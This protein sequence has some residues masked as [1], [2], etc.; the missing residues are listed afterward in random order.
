MGAETIALPDAVRQPSPI[1]AETELQ[2]LF[3]PTHLATLATTPLRREHARLWR[4]DAIHRA[5]NLAQMTTS[6][7]DVAGHPSRRWLPPNVNLTQPD[8]ACDLAFLRGSGQDADPEYMLSNSFGFG[9]INA[10]LVFKRAD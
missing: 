4:A 1:A 7:A 8:P 3:A 5:K 6:L 9:G 2:E 10:S